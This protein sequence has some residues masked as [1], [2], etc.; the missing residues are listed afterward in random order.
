MGILTPR[1]HWEAHCEKHLLSEGWKPIENWRSCYFHPKLKL[2]LN[3]YVDDF[4]MSGPAA[5]MKEG[6]AKIRKGLEVEDPAA[7]SLYLGCYHE[8]FERKDPFGHLVRGRSYNQED[9][10]RSCIER[11]QDLSGCKKLSKAATP[12]LEDPPADI[13]L[14]AGELQPHA[15]AILMKILYAARISRPDLMRAVCYL[16]CC[17][18][19]WDTHCDKQLY[20]LICYIS[21]TLH[22]RHVCYV[23]AGD[24]G[25]Y[26]LKAYADADFAGCRFTKRSTSGGLLVIEG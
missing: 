25:L 23:S 20:R 18:T 11:Y 8:Y 7:L 10:L 26:L 9:F 15:A 21:C 13:D 12:F 24:V 1:G 4:K 16:A 19:R 5:N 6:W 2:L 22:H 3:V 14:P 17:I